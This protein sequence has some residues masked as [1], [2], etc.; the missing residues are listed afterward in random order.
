MNSYFLFNAIS[1]VVFVTFIVLFVA[2]NLYL[3][4]HYFRHK[5][6]YKNFLT[7]VKYFHVEINPVIQVIYYL[8]LFG[9]GSLTLFTLLTYNAELRP[10]ALPSGLMFI[11]VFALYEVYA[12]LRN[13]DE[14]MTQ[15]FQNYQITTDALNQKKKAE[16]SIQQTLEYKTNVSSL[17]HHF[18]L[19]IKQVTDPSVFKLRDSLVIIDEFVSK[20]TKTIDAYEEEVLSRFQ[21]AL[22]NFFESH[23]SIKVE[24]PK[25][26]LNFE[27]QYNQVRSEIYDKYHALFN[28]TLYVLIDTK[29]YKTSTIITDGLQILKDNNFAPSQ[30]LIELIL[31]TIDD[32]EGSP[33]ELIDY[34]LSRK[35]IELEELITYAI[36]KK[37]IWVFRSNLF[38]TQEQLQ[39]ISERLIKEDAYTLG[40]AFI[41]NYFSNLKNVLA[42]MDKLKETNRTVQLFVNYQKVMN[43]D[44]TFYDESR[45]LENK[46]MSLK[47]FF[48]HKKVS[49]TVKRQLVNVSDLSKAYKL[50]EEINDFYT[51]VKDKYDGL[52]L[53]SV[54]SLLMY[55]GI[56]DQVKLFDLIKTSRLLKDFENRLLIDDLVVT[57]LLLYGLFIVFNDDEDLYNEVITVLKNTKELEVALSDVNLDTT[58]EYHK[59]LGQ[60]IIKKHLLKEYKSRLSNVVISIENERLTLDKIAAII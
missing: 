17:I 25:T 14:D 6:N 12:I 13:K 23:V 42:F 38:E 32:I 40:V 20:Q 37:I 5:M 50:K 45:V 27:V 46:V 26:S 7:K 8:S 56:D 52:M 35:I 53:S 19:Q 10:Y 1:L 16:T 55:S 43:I 3:I 47:Q 9:L 21:K 44:E 57:T 31:I 33:R 30:D 54:Q 59:K 2:T 11:L 15:H 60:S 48:E 41:S 39:T 29:K 36:N 24:L 49:E 22:D 51:K 58:F 34:I 4:N 28:E 18:E